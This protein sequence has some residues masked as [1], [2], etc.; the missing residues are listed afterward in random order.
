MNR[1]F[2]SYI[3][4]IIGVFLITSCTVDND[5]GI[6]EDPKTDFSRNNYVMATEDA[7]E[8]DITSF[9]T[10]N[11]DEIDPDISYDLIG[12]KGLFINSNPST[13]SGHL[14]FGRY[15]FS[16]AKDKKGFSSSPGL[17]RMTL[18]RDDRMYVDVELNVSQANLFP[19]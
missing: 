12:E 13:S 4:L 17:Y 5:N 14:S 16:Q 7:S 1:L 8:V 19:A 3:Y 18:N 11:L 9:F 2:P 15:V 6:N 10:F